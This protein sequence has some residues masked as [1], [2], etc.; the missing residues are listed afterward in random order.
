[1][2]AEVATRNMEEFPPF[3]EEQNDYSFD[4]RSGR[5]W[6]EYDD[7]DYFVPQ[8]DEEPEEPEEDP[9]GWSS[10]TKKKKW[11]KPKEPTATSYYDSHRR[12]DQSNWKCLKDV[13]EEIREGRYEI[14]ARNGDVPKAARTMLLRGYAMYEQ[15]GWSIR[16][17]N[18]IITAKQMSRERKRKCSYEETAFLRVNDPEAS[19]VHYIVYVKPI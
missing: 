6:S 1:M 10:V 4:F 13:P 19:S 5:L 17:T 9:D 16:G 7:E 18:P 12:M 8:E 15:Q 3:G 14:Q 11:K 2:A